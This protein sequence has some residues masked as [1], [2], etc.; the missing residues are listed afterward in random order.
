MR[1]FVSEM[2]DIDPAVTGTPIQVYESSLLM[3]RAFS[4][5]ALFS[6]VAVAILVFLDFLS[7]SAL[8]FILCPLGLGVLWLAELM[9]GF[10]IHLNLANFFAIPILIGIGV[11]DAVHFFHRYKE[12]HDVE[13]AIYTTGTTLTLTTLTTCIGFGSLIFASHKGLQ[14]LGLLM[15]LGTVTYWFSCVI[16][17][18]A[19]IKI[20]NRK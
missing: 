18:P 19:L 6:F 20:I 12:D 4:Q 2:R 15:A 1:R 5:I 11:D 16:F 17:L 10:G 9:G 7:L 13:R 3:R 14:S 8:L